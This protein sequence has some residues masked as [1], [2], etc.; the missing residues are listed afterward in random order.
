MM[1]LF[2]DLLLI[3]VYVLA[4]IVPKNNL[5]YIVGSSL[6][7]HFADNSK[8]LYLYVLSRKEQSKVKTV[9]ITKNIDVYHY[10][11]DKGCSVEYLYTVKGVATVLRASRVFLS[12]RLD[13]INGALLGGAEII[14]LWHGVPLKKIDYRYKEGLRGWGR[15][16]IHDLL[17]YSYFLHCDKLI[18]NSESGK[19]VLG[20]IFLS[21]AQG[22]SD[23]DDILVLGQPRCD[24]L[25][26]DY[27]FDSNNFPEII[28][29]YDSVIKYDYIVS[30]LPTHR[31]QFSETVIDLIDYEDLLRLNHFCANNSIL[32]YI[33]PHFLEIN[34]LVDLGVNKLSNV[35]IYDYA[36]PYP[37][38]RY[39]DLLITDY[40]SV[41]DDFIIT[42]RP[43]IFYTPDYDKYKEEVDFYY[44]YFSVT[45]GLKCTSLR[46]LI[47][48]LRDLIHNVDLY[49]VDRSEYI[50][51]SKYIFE[52][53]C[54]NI[55]DLFWVA[56]S[57]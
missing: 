9:W 44:D 20:E 8:Y 35:D 55:Y 24:A 51:Q 10:L 52:N 27:H 39:T 38:L 34:E 22:V 25:M 1:Q 53:N 6:G 26:S 18:T 3:P 28:N 54:K 29:L 43:I 45:P 15:F 48:G 41:Y 30:W 56:D 37:L 32:L 11:N 4:K 2:V 19:R 14:Q 36:D 12:H 57:S 49:C 40:T 42:N 46:C 7:E 33:K 21:G 13:D 17:K 16:L 23:V 50:S 47:G 5:L 31:G